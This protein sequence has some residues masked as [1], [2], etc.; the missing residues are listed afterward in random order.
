MLRKVK[1]LIL[2][3][4][5]DPDQHKNLIAARGSP[6]AHACHV[7]STSISVFVSYP[8]HRMTDRQ[9]RQTNTVIT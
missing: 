7:W 3:L 6:L 4:H 9:L 1:K 8:V 5:P 2:D